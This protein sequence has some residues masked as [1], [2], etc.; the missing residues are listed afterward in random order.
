MSQAKS[1]S[2]S[3]FTKTV[4]AAVKKAVQKHPKFKTQAQQGVVLSYLI[5]GIPFDEA[6]LANVTIA[7]TQAF[8][9]ELAAHIAGSEA[10]LAAGTAT[11]NTSV[12]PRGVIYGTGGHIICGYPP[13]TEPVTIEQ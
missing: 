2:L 13:V 9:Q 1:I 3:Q 10:S 6:V 5:R 4:E 8:A 11:D 7:E 12:K